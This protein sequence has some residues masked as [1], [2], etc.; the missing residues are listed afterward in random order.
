MI[1]GFF[2]LM[3]GLV[4][5]GIIGATA[6]V[7]VMAH[8]GWDAPQAQLT[9]AVACGVAVASIA[10]GIAIASRQWGF[11]L[12]FAVALLAGEA[13][14]MLTTGERVLAGRDAAAES[15]RLATI[16][17]EQAQ[18]RLDDALAVHIIT[19]PRLDAAQKAKE[20]ADAAVASE[21]SKK[22]CASNCRALLN[23]AVDDAIAELGAARAEMEDQ[24]RAAAR[25]VE[26][27]RLALDAL[28]A[29][30]SETL[31]ADKLHMSGATLDLLLAALTSLGA[32]GLGATLLAFGVHSGHH[33]ERHL[34]KHA[35]RTLEPVSALI[36]RLPMPT[37]QDVVS[38]DR[39]PALALPATPD[40]HVAKFG[41]D[42]MK[43]AKSGRIAF[44]DLHAAYLDWCAA[45]QL[46]PLPAR[47][48]TIAMSKLFSE[49]PGIGYDEDDK[50]DL[51]ITGAKLLQERPSREGVL[52]LVP[53]K[54]ARLA[55]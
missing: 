41:L 29:P 50:G 15:I 20:M 4:G 51:F 28:P 24:Q 19:T 30:K 27:A 23:K 9:I 1:Q 22:G 2:R 35:A 10:F 7:T 3:F 48:I 11:V 55:G 18:R 38:T 45:K 54:N 31:L 42:T 37:V 32:N 16:K 5:C 52:T 47:D 49:T 14:G 39:K 12:A 8:G 44:N 25:Q 46:P 53:D 34:E 21:A 33:R 36:A 13:A 17:R 6:Y 26:A 43:P 40:Q